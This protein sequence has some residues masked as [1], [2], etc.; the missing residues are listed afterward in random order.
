M[1]SKKLQ[2]IFKTDNSCFADNQTVA[3]ENGRK[4]TLVLSKGQKCCCIHVDNGLIKSM[5]MQKCDYWFHVSEKDDSEIKENHNIFVELKGQ[6][7]LKAYSQIISAINWF[8]GKMELPQAK[9]HAAIVASKVPM[10][11]TETQKMKMDFKHKHGNRLEIK[12]REMEFR[13]P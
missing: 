2:P 12:S 11:S 7:V 6:E 3:Q 8:K 9:R 13:L 4:F 10:T 5:T 1:L